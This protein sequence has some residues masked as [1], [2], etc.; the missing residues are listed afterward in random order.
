MFPLVDGHLAIGDDGEVAIAGPDRD[1]SCLGGDSVMP[2]GIGERDHT[3][4]VDSGD[5]VSVRA[6]SERMAH[7]K[8]AI[9]VRSTPST[10]VTVPRSLYRYPLL[11]A[12]RW[13]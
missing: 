2:I 3:G 12:T 4:F 1:S 7:P 10:M 11:M 5:R 8:A 13:P 6:K 9:G